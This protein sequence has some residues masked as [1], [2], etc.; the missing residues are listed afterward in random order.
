MN[1]NQSSSSVTRAYHSSHS[2]L[3][4]SNDSSPFIQHDL[5]PPSRHPNSSFLGKTKEQQMEEKRVRRLIRNREAA[6]RYFLFFKVVSDDL[7]W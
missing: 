1:R 5:N 3:N 4:L 6:K 2:S 7:P